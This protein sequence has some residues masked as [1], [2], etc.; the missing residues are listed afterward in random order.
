MERCNQSNPER[1]MREPPGFLA[2]RPALSGSLPFRLLSPSYRKGSKIL[3]RVRRGSIEGVKPRST[4]P[5]DP[6]ETK[7]V[8]RKR[9]KEIDY[10]PT[11]AYRLTFSDAGI[12]DVP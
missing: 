10:L 4:A 1:K 9:G 11:P 8:R 2:L 6:R 3:A 7:G 5:H 12:K